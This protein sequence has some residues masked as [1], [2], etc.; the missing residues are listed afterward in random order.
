MQNSE[1]SKLKTIMWCARIPLCLK[2][3]TDP[4]LRSPM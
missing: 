4:S 3:P 2:N 1:D